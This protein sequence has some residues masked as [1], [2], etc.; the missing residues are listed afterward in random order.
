MDDIGQPGR[1]WDAGERHP[2]A[3]WLS[4]DPLDQPRDVM[5]FIGM[6]RF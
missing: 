5:I 2:P 3:F 6:Y 1:V 4:I